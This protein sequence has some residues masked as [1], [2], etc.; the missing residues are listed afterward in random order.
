MFPAPRTGEQMN[1]AKLGDL[2]D[3]TLAVAEAKS[4]LIVILDGPAD[5]RG[6]AMKAQVKDYFKMIHN[7]ER[8]IKDLREQ[9]T[10]ELYEKIKAADKEKANSPSDGG[11]E[12]Q[13]DQ[14]PEE[15]APEVH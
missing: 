1:R 14:P 15:A 9:V 2:L 4:G 8:V 6:I 5:S 11:E 13:A 12:D 7:L 10:K 3:A